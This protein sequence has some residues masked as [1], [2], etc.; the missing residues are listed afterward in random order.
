MN[1]SCKHTKPTF[2]CPVCIAASKPVS[3]KQKIL[4]RMAKLSEALAEL[5][6]SCGDLT[7]EVNAIC[8]MVDEISE[9]P[10]ER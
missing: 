8:G 10:D 2:G 7:C 5:E 6:N 4:D 1:L 9:V 3:P